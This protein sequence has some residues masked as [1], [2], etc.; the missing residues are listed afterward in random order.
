MDQMMIHSIME[1]LTKV[2][3]MCIDSKVMLDLGG[4]I[5]VTG[6]IESP[7]L[8]YDGSSFGGLSHIPKT[9]LY[10]I[11]TGRNYKST[12]L[13]IRDKNKNAT[14]LQKAYFAMLCAAW[15]SEMSEVNDLS[16]NR[17]TFFIHEVKAYI[18]QFLNSV[19]PQIYL[20]PQV[21]D[22]SQAIFSLI[23]NDILR[24]MFS[25]GS[26]NNFLAEGYQPS[27]F[28][29]Y[30]FWIEHFTK[31]KYACRDNPT[32]FDVLDDKMS[33]YIEELKMM[34]RPRSTD[35]IDSNYAL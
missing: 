31:L 19:V 3:Y 18:Y 21:G 8:Q 9:Y 26:F 10:R 7:F 27:L 17:I 23:E 25:G 32:Q 35:A 20:N 14:N 6:I 34:A 4:S 29:I 30:D 33:G 28:I 1:K 24:P 5:V 2:L 12:Y 16:Y 22:K 13:S 15:C 11:S